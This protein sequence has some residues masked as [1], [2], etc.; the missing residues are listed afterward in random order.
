MEHV[1]AQIKLAGYPKLLE[2]ITDHP[3]IVSTIKSSFRG[4]LKYSK[5]LKATEQ[6]IRKNHTDMTSAHMPWS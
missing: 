3:V 5:I 4:K 2:I 6:D 1:L